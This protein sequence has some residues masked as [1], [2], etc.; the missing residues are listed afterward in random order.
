MALTDTAN[1]SDLD[2]GVGAECQVLK[3]GPK[4]QFSIEEDQI[5]MIFAAAHGMKN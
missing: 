3:A 5:L 4:Q 2:H 1:R